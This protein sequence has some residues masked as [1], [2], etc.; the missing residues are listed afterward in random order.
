MSIDGVDV[1]DVTLDSLRSAI[2][3]VQQDVYLF[4]GT[5][6]ENIAYG[7]P[8]QAMRRSSRRRS[9][10]AFMISSAACPTATIRLSESAERVFRAGRSNAWPSRACSC[11]ILAF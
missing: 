10:R 4:G 9:A 2:G 3:I 11:V 7:K 1:R 8:G 6:R 5:I